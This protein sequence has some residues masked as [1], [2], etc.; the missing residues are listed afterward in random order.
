MLWFQIAYMVFAVAFAWFNAYLIK[1]RRRIFHFWNGFL[2]LCWAV[3]CGAH[4]WWGGGVALLL[5]TK[6]IFDTFLSHFRGLPLLYFNPKGRSIM[7]KIEHKIFGNDVLEARIVY[8][9]IAI[10]LNA[11]YLIFVQ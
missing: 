2:H 1:K 3:Y 7:D 8:T 5:T 10:I 6:V 4:W 9:C 11:V